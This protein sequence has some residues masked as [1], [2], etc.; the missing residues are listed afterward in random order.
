M[1]TE[2]IGEK[3]LEMENNNT[4]LLKINYSDSNYFHKDNETTKENDGVEEGEFVEIFLDFG[5]ILSDFF[6]VFDGFPDESGATEEAG[7]ELSF[8]NCEPQHVSTPVLQKRGRGRPPKRIRVKP[9]KVE[10][11]YSMAMDTSYAEDAVIGNMT[12]PPIVLKF[13]L[14]VKQER[15]K[16]E[17]MILNQTEPV[18]IKRGRGRPKKI[19]TSPSEKTFIEEYSHDISYN[20]SDGSLYRPKKPSFLRTADNDLENDASQIQNKLISNISEV[21]T[22]LRGRPRTNYLH[23]Q[24]MWTPKTENFRK[25]RVKKAAITPEE[26]PVVVKG[27]RGRPR[28]HPIIDPSTVKVRGRPKESYDP[29]HIKLLLEKKQMKEK[30]Q[31]KKNQVGPRGRPTKLEAL[32]LLLEDRRQQASSDSHTS[33]KCTTPNQESDDDS[34][35]INLEDSQLTFPLATML[36]EI[37]GSKCG[38][39]IENKENLLFVSSKALCDNRKLKEKLLERTDPVFREMKQKFKQELKSIQKVEV[40]A[41]PS[42]PVNPL[43]KRRRGPR[44]PYKKKNA[45]PDP[46]IPERVPIS[47]RLVAKRAAEAAAAAARALEPPPEPRRPAVRKKIVPINTERQLPESVPQKK[48]SYV[49]PT[50]TIELIPDMHEEPEPLYPSDLDKFMKANNLTYRR[51]PVPKILISKNPFLMERPMSKPLIVTKN[52]FLP[53]N[54]RQPYAQNNMI[55]KKKVPMKRGRPKNP[56]PMQL[57]NEN[58]SNGGSVSVCINLISS[59]EEDNDVSTLNYTYP[60]VTNEPVSYDDEPFDNAYSLFSENNVSI[61]LISD[62]EDGQ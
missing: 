58:H 55:M 29:E 8:L 31:L 26:K 41:K 54:N 21:K 56:P 36:E 53:Q 45:T 28:I 33:T 6:T 7:Q 12:A 59:D 40:K 61:S 32:K 5:W 24:R 14:G 23:V 16:D 30:E 37:H 43:I 3:P 48:K 42:P 25:H 1:L 2:N 47:Q 49:T 15:P 34:E 38:E 4:E 62:E 51:E 57:Q 50:C 9:E 52:P 22:R 13:K 20:T 46:Y 17:G 19:K 11:E 10:R 27:V 18:I 60:T 35:C 39:S 44:G